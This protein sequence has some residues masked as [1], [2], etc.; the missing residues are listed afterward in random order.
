MTFNHL[1]R[2]T[3]LF[4]GLALIPWFVIYG[5]SSLAFQHR[6]LFTDDPKPHWSDAVARPYDRQIL[7]GADLRRVGAEILADADLEGLYRARRPKPNRIV[8]N[9][10]DF[11]SQTR[12]IYQIDEGRLTVEERRYGFDAFLIFMHI[13][14]GFVQ[15][16]FLSDLWAVVVDIVCLGI[17][18][19]V[20]S[21]LYMWWLL[22]PT[23][24]WGAAA[25]GAG[26]V[27][28]GIFIAV[29]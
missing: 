21:G 3:H 16:S 2:R 24:R 17:L 27:S 13:R 5:L 25:L 28:F 26:F 23:R 8:V 18:V 1:N 9:R 14:A 10:F 12:L 19:W 20:A 6:T 29:L 22:S 4:L 11:W 15:E 7:E